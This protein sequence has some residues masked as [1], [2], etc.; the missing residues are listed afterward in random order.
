M[1]YLDANYKNIKIN[2][3]CTYMEFEEHI[4]NIHR[5]EVDESRALKLLYFPDINKVFIKYNDK[6]YGGDRYGLRLSNIHYEPYENYIAIISNT[7][8]IAHQ[9]N[10]SFLEDNMHL[11]DINTHEYVLK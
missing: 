10:N 8:I 7:L 6:L 1:Y 11:F 2:N 3:N 5:Y 9:T 4:I